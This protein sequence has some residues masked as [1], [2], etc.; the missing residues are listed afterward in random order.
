MRSPRLPATLRGRLT[1]ALAVAL[2]VTL[3]A[4]AV[5]MVLVVQ[6]VLTDRLD[7][8]LRAAG[9]RFAVS[10]ER[11][12]DGDTD[13][14]DGDTDDRYRR[15]EGQLEGTLGARVHGGTVAAAA[16][17]GE[18]ATTDAVPAGARAQLARLRPG[19]DPRTVDLAG[20]G[21][22]RVLVVA[23]RD[24]DL[25][26]TGLP[27]ESI[28]DT[29]DRLTLIVVLVVA[30]ALVL[31]LLGAAG[32]LRAMLEP[33]RRV[34]RTASEVAGMSLATGSGSLPHRVEQGG[35]SSEVDTLA[36]A[37]NAMLEEVES[38]LRTRADSEA[39]LRRFLADA[40]HE[41]R[42]PVAVV[43]SHAELARREGGALLPGEVARSLDRITAQAE[44][45][46]HLVEDLLLLARL[47]SG[48]PLAREPVDVVRLALDAA[49]DAR[50]AAPEHHWRLALPDDALDV[51]GDAHALG[52]V[53]ANLLANAASHT[54]AG[55]T[56]TVRVA[57]A[58]EHVVLT[59]ADDGPGMP[60]GV[61]DRAFDR[62]VRGTSERAV[63][64]GSSGL[65]LA[66][67]AA[68]VAAHGGTVSLSSGKDGTVARVELPVPAGP[69]AE[70]A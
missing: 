8:Q 5:V 26:V 37:F 27:A 9:G 7:D 46:G 63:S 54:P 53:V 31:I 33:L 58:G 4:A 65:G 51:T 22:Y 29:I 62:F 2:T 28:E 56:V 44:R 21:E 70:N 67:V 52:Q 17:V 38:A 15:T 49:D 14:G 11:G 69:A 66:I 59:V 40:S 50:I 6:R 23:E 18:H 57:R 35:G 64:R 68:I 48:R 41:L 32:L 25:Q 43:R 20:L 10:L 34:T 12:D 16:V 30:V 45:M 3:A 61:A 42:T 47:D 36:R 19:D 55:T 60:A 24:G 1:A 13:D 39:R